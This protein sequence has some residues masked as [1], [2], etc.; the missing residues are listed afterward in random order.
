MEVRTRFLGLFLFI[1][2]A[3]GIT[4]GMNI[5]TDGQ[6]SPINM[7]VARWL[8]PRVGH[9]PEDVKVETKRGTHATQ[10]KME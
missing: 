3:A 6:R 9:P 10:D 5:A 2:F 4:I 7:H 1:V 8:A